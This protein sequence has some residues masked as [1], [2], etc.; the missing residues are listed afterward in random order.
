MSTSASERTRLARIRTGLG[1]TALGL[2]LFKVG[3]SRAAPVEI[4]A[5]AV[6]F[7]LGLFVATPRIDQGPAGHSRRAVATAVITS[8]VVVLAVLAV[9]G[10]SVGT[11]RQ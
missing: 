6:G 11:S 10:S 1:A 4:A 3:V 7:A 8:G 5:G 2:L 9:L